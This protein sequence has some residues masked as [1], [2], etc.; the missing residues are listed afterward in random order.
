MGVAGRRRKI[1]KMRK[2]CRERKSNLTYT[3]F[4]FSFLPFVLLMF[5]SDTII[6]K[7]F[8]GLITPKIFEL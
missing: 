2:K 6:I 1:T 3:Y 7:Y 8:S 5:I 4:Q